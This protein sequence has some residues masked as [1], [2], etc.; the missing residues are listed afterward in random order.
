[1]ELKQFVQPLRKWWWLL[2]ASTLVAGLAS[3]FVVLQ[4]P[5]QYLARTTLMIGQA[6][7][8]PN[9]S[10]TEFWLTQ[11]LAQTYAEIA[12]RTPV[13]NSAMRALNLTWLPE[14]T[15]RAVPETQLIEIAVTDSSPERA[16]AVANELANQLTFQSPTGPQQGDQTRLEFINAQL[17]NLQ[18]EIVETESQIETGRAELANAVGARQIADLQSQIAA[19]QNKHIS[20]TTN[21]SNLLD[22]TRQGAINTLTIIEPAAAPTQPVGP[23]QA[24]TVLLAALI[25][26]SLAA[27]AAFLLEYLDDRVGSADEV[28]RLVQIATLASFARIDSDEGDLPTVSQ[29]RSP[30]SEAFRGLRTGIQFSTIDNPNPERARLLVSSSNPSEGKSLT[31][32]NLA[33]V[34]AQAGRSVLVLD[35]DLRRPAQHRLFNVSQ[36]RGLTNFLLNFNLGEPAA[37]TLAALGRNI[38]PTSI[39]GLHVLPSGPIPPNPSE[40]LGSAKMEAALE[41]LAAEYDYVIVDSPPVLAVTDAA[42]LSRRVDGVVLIVDV[43]TTRRGQLKQAVEH[44]RAGNARLLGA[45]LNKLDPRAQVGYGYYGTQNTY[46]QE[47][48]EGEQAG[49]AANGKGNGRIRRRAVRGAAPEAGN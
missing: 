48:L 12:K 19:L 9:P 3:F 21:Y 29:P 2:L 8:D 32:A 38:Q 43:A 40:L 5:G 15:V 49:Q 30:I 11:Q 1:M 31:V 4:Q 35:A 17:D 44:L 37:V 10:G 41:T 24:L 46:Y 22:N 23:N 42:V 28:R 7:D 18:A 16:A 26:L 33:V 14:Y 25:G 13:R 47:P 34:M 20:L 6:I 36:S 39:E 45:V 27:G